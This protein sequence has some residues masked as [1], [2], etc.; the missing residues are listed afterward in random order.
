[1]PGPDA[2]ESGVTWRIADRDA[3]LVFE[4]SD[5]VAVFHRPSNQTQ[6]L[7][8]LATIVFRALLNGDQS[9]DTLMARIAEEAEVDPDFDLRAWLPALLEAFAGFGFVERKAT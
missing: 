2:V 3:F 5:R 8:P 1:M 9:M 4:V 7:N 6:L